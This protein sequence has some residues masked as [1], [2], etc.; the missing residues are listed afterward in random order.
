[1]A[2]YKYFGVILKRCNFTRISLRCQNSIRRRL[3]S[4]F[5]GR[6]SIVIA[7]ALQNNCHALF[8]ANVISGA[9]RAMQRVTVSIAVTENPRNVIPTSVLKSCQ[10]QRSWSCTKKIALEKSC[11]KWMTLKVIQGRREWRYSIG[12]IR[13]WLWH[14]YASSF[15]S[16]F[17][18]ILFLEGGGLSVV[19]RNPSPILPHNH[20]SHEALPHCDIARGAQGSPA[21]NSW[22][23]WYR[24][25]RLTLDRQTDRQ[26][27][28]WSEQAGGR[29]DLH[30]LTCSSSISFYLLY[31]NITHT[32]RNSSNLRL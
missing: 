14:F 22:G 27:V 11:N 12:K 26:I 25:L 1:V 13:I 24:R 29:S 23:W 20:T 7:S 8:S 6:T 16:G 10:L 31:G 21:A 9:D 15:S 32:H 4:F 3:G 19:V 30:I 18:D 2:Q 5:L 28:D 17:L